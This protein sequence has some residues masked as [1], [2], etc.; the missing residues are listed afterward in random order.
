MVMA[1]VLGPRDAARAKILA[2][3]ISARMIERARAGSYT[4][5]QVRDVPAQL[6]Q[7]HFT[8]AGLGSAAVHTVGSQLRASVRCARLNL[9]DAWP[10]RGPFDVIFCRNVM[11]YFDAETQGRL[12]RRFHEI[13]APGGHLFV[14]HSES[15]SS[16]D[17]TLRNVRPAVYV[18]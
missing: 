8:K 6:L 13:L 9:M 10:M 14:G 2:T 16:M 7:A 12:V 15:L 18:K 3:D 5:D 11:I 1:A 4:A 17:H